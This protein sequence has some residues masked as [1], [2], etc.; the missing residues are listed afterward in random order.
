[1]PSWPTNKT[2]FKTEYEPPP[3]TEPLLG[4]LAFWKADQRCSVDGKPKDEKPGKIRKVV[5]T[6]LEVT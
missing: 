3:T 6:S 1:M 5:A 2:C 4:N